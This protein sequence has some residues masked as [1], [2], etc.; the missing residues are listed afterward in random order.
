[1]AL[2]RQEKADFKTYLNWE[3]T[4]YFY[5]HLADEYCQ[6]FHLADLRGNLLAIWELALKSWKHFSVVVVESVK[7]TSFWFHS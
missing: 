2:I 4:F 5:F 3:N 7:S 1:M 6:A